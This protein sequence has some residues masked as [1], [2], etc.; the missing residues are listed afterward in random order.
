MN[1]TT[2]KALN[3]EPKQYKCLKCKISRTSIFIGYIYKYDFVEN[4]CSLTSMNEKYQQADRFTFVY[5][6]CFSVF[7]ERV[8]FAQVRLN[9]RLSCYPAPMGSY[10]TSAMLTCRLSTPTI[11]NSL[12]YYTIALPVVRQLMLV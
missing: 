3:G 4:H 8:S 12:P 10:V 11:R 7:P 9:R 6:E 1:G 2:I 5:L